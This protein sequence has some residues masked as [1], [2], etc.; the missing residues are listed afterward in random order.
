[1]FFSEMESWLALQVAP[2]HENKV[3]TILDYKGFEQFFPT[4]KSRR[5]W[6]D[7]IKVIIRP[8]FPGYIFCRSRRSKIAA[9]LATPGV[10]RIVSF[11]G[12]PCVVPD[13][14]I[15]KLHTIVKA[16]VDPRPFPYLNTGERVRIIRDGVLFGMVGILTKIKNRSR[17]V[18]SVD[19]IT[20]SISIEVDYQDV[21]SEDK[22]TG[23]ECKS[24]G[25]HRL[26]RDQSLE[27]PCS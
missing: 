17:L 6:S 15:G 25:F 21:A 4:Y 23:M 1:L 5:L 8:L 12:K 2:Q 14:D 9:I 22:Y 10:N 19:M 7:R 26:N 3:A 18:V 24:A 27:T 13:E 16:G 20:K 11:G